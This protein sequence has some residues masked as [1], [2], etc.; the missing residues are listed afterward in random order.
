MCEED[1]CCDNLIV[2]VAKSF[3]FFTTGAIAG[4]NAFSWNARTVMIRLAVHNYKL[5]LAIQ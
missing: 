1:E 4:P 5:L 2:I 3:I